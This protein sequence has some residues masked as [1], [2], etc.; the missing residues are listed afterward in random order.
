MFDKNGFK[1]DSMRKRGS[2]LSTHDDLH[3]EKQNSLGIH[4]FNQ[5]MG[6]KT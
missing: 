3:R 6:L 2:E 4:F 5:Q 1:P